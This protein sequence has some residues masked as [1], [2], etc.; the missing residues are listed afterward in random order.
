MEAP[1]EQKYIF[2]IDNTKRPTQKKLI[3]AIS[4]GIGTCLAE[5]NDI[6]LE[7]APVHPK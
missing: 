4:C 3:Q 1:P 5:P 6:P 7:Y 2:G